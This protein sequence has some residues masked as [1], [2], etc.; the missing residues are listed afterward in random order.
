MYQTTC[1]KKLEALVLLLFQQRL[2][3]LKIDVTLWVHP[4]NTKRLLHLLLFIV[5]K[6]EVNG[7]L[8]TIRFGCC[9]L[10]VSAY[11]QSGL[12]LWSISEEA[13]GACLVVICPHESVDIGGGRWDKA[14][15]RSIVLRF[16]A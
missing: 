14:A 1:L 10:G 7:G 3:I 13:Y 2:V 6:I 9:R 16:H 5:A 11:M 8:K 12:V 4:S 15:A